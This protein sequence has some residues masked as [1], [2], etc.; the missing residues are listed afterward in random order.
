MQEGWSSHPN[1]DDEYRALDAALQALNVMK[2]DVNE[3][4]Q[5]M[6]SCPDIALV[7]VLGQRGLE[8]IKQ[9]EKRL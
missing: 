4:I 3:L 5:H 1:W 2:V 7:A 8:L 9:V 6:R